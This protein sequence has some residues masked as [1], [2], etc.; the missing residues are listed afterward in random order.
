[1]K[2][3]FLL[4]DGLNMIRRVYAAHPGEDSPEKVEGAGKACSQSLLR[5]LRES[6]PTHAVC[7]LEGEGPSWR[8]QVYAEYKAGRLPMPDALKAGL[9]EIEKEFSRLGVSSLSFPALEADDVIATLATKVAFRQGHVVILSTDKMFLQLLSN[10]IQVRD[11]FRQRDLDGSYV[12]EKFGVKP[13]QFVDFLSLTGDSTNNIRGVPGVGQKTAATL[14]KDFGSLD[15]ILSSS[16]TLK[17]KLGERLKDH[18]EEARAARTL[19]FLKTDLDLGVN[20]I[21]FRYP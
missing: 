2:V 18:A 5:A 1:M 11:H 4:V 12:R 16:S 14:L 15:A 6:R 21:S 13:E 8:H 7:V 19:I 3:R 17:G 20:L 9:T 10:R